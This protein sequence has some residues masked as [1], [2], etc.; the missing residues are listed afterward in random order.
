MAAGNA[1][2]LKELQLMKSRN[3]WRGRLTIAI[4]TKLDGDRVK[5]ANEEASK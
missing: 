4:I 5:V 1:L 2:E 3:E